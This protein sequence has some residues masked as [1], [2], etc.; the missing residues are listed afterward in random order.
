MNAKNSQ[1][2]C[3][4]ACV[5]QFYMVENNAFLYSSESPCAAKLHLAQYSYV[6]TS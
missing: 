6:S 3:F 2:I 4:C 5:W 1:V